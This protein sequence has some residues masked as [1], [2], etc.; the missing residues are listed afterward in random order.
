MNDVLEKI[1]KY[2]L[3]FSFFFF[4]LPANVSIKNVINLYLRSIGMLLHPGMHLHNHTWKIFGTF[5][6]LAYAFFMKIKQINV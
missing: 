2:S 4:L 5:Y 3:F 6:F 1:I